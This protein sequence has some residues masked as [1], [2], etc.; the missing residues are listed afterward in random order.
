MKFPIPITSDEVENGLFDY[1]RKNTLCD[2]SYRIRINGEMYQ[3]V[4][5]ITPEGSDERYITEF[6]GAFKRPLGSTLFASSSFEL[7]PVHNREISLSPFFK[8]MKFESTPGYDDSVEEFESL[9]T[10]KDQL[11]LID[12]IRN[13]TEDYFSERPK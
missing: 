12:E 6:S 4:V 3:N 5:G 1:I 7:I 9:A 10:G 2:I 13:R 11:K 8:G